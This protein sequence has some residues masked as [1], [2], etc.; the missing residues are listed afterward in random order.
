MFKIMHFNPFLDKDNQQGPNDTDNVI[1]QGGFPIDS[2]SSKY[3]RN[4][5]K[6]YLHDR[7]QEKRNAKVYISTGRKGPKWQV[8]VNKGNGYEKAK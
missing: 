4:E 2:A 5:P 7:Y 3:M 6:D 1:R 8:S